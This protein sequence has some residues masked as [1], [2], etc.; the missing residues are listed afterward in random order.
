MINKKI[1]IPAVKAAHL[2]IY[3]LNLNQFNHQ[4]TVNLTHYPSSVIL[5]P[6]DVLLDLITLIN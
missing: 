4:H 1:L 3:W 5:V 6:A 2:T